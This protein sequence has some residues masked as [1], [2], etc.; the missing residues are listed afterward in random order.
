MSEQLAAVVL[1]INTRQ[2]GEEVCNAELGKISGGFGVEIR[3][4]GVAVVSV[5]F[6]FI[7]GQ[8]THDEGLGHRTHIVEDCMKVGILQHH[9]SIGGSMWFD[10]AEVRHE[11][12]AIEGVC[13]GV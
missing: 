11:E 7:I 2:I 6:V 12:T 8:G 5:S 13:N 4:I 3:W 1:A 10:R 9:I